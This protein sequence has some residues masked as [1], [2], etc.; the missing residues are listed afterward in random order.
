MKL[1]AEL[2]QID[3]CHYNSVTMREIENNT[4]AVPGAS[5][6]ARFQVETRKLLVKTLLDIMV[7]P[8]FAMT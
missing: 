3:R 1:K 8:V 5:R 6:W 7:S 4:W 2:V